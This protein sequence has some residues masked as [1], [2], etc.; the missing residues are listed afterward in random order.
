MSEDE[1]HERLRAELAK[2]LGRTPI[3]EQRIV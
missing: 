3:V 2:D 1:M